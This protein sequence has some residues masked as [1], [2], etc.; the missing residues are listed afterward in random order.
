MEE[1]NGNSRSDLSVERRQFTHGGITTRPEGQRSLGDQEV[2]SGGQNGMEAFCTFL[3]LLSVVAGLI[4]VVATLT[5]LIP[6]CN[7]DP[8]QSSMDRE[9]GGRW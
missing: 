5:P 8:N 4:T 2:M 6:L 3:L 9:G 1:D 7:P